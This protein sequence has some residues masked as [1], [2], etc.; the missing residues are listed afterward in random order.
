MDSVQIG[1]KVF[2]EPFKKTAFSASTKEK[3]QKTLLFPI[4]CQSLDNQAVSA[5]PQIYFA[6]TTAHVLSCQVGMP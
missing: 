1:G 3:G 2:T 6:L 4:A 5:R